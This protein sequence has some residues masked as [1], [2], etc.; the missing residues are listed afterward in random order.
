MHAIEIERLTKTFRQR[1]GGR[2]RAVRGI[3]FCVE[4]GELFALLGVNGAGKTT[5][6]RML[7]GLIRPDGGMARVLGYDLVKDPVQIKRISGSSPQETA[8]APLLTVR[9]NLELTAGL[10]GYGKKE[11]ADRASRMMGRLRLTDV[12]DRRAGKLSGGYA[13][14]LSIGMGLISEPKILYLDEPTM[15]L[16]V[17]SRRELWDIIRELKGEVTIILTTHHMEEAEVLADRVGVMVSG[18]LR[19]IGSVGELCARTETHTLEDAFV[20]IATGKPT[21]GEGRKEKRT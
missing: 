21:A 10:Y 8:V 20:A 5:T 12:A 17:L 7:T 9:E 1:G 6:I 11:A 14:R 13:H 15:G 16:D 18:R 3:S 4:Q 19:E 2:V